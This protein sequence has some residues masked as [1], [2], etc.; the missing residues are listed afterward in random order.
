MLLD[1][2]SS[3]S[4]IS[5]FVAANVS[6]WQSLPQPVKVRVANG[7]VLSCTHELRDQIWGTQG[8]TFTTTLKIIPLRGYEIILGMDW[9][10]YHSPMKVHWAD[11]WIQF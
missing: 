6:P 9:L 1:S 8:H 11:K 2:G 4:F 7:E 5:E 10:E 3:N